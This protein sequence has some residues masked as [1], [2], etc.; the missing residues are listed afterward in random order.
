MSFKRARSEQQIQERIQEIINAASEIYNEFGYDGLSFSAISKY[1]NFTRPNIYKYFK[2]KDEILLEILKVD[3]AS[4]ITVLKNS[5]KINK[6]YSLGEIAEIWVDSLTKHS[7]FLELYSF[8]FTTIEK[9]VSVEALAKF[10]QDTIPTYQMQLVNLV[11]QLFPNAA[12]A[13]VYDFIVAQITIAFG[14]YPM[15]QLNDLQLKAIE[16][17]GIDYAAPDFKRSYKLYVYQLM[18]CLE[19]DI[20]IQN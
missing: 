6:I 14:L 19:H 3:M 9:N 16:M 4:W 20:E 7:R 2:T 11:E 8:L 12:Q 13:H 17:A 15:C 10:K 1:T 18:Y 5:F